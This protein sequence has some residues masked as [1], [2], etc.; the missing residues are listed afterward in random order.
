MSMDPKT[1]NALVHDRESEL[2]DDRFL[3]RYDGSI[4]RQVRRDLKRLMGAV[5]EARRALD[6]ACGTGYLA[7]GIA[8]AGIA[9]EVHATDLSPKMLE[10]C[11]DNAAAVGATVQTALSDAERLPYADDSFDLVCARG[12]LHHVPSPLEALCEM[13]RVLAPGGTAIV[14]AEPTPSGE[15]QVGTVVGAAV[16]VLEGARSVLR[17][18]RDEEHHQWELASMAA[19]LHTFE[20]D[21]IETLAIKAGFEDITVSTAA[22]AWV[23]ALGINY[24]LAGELRPLAANPLARTAGRVWVEGA[25][26]FDRAIGD[27]IVPR[28]WRHTVQA[29]L[30]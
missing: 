4:G 23:L 13:R 19:N 6:V 5:P 29:V 24:Y 25:A 1:L 30:R 27:R 16:R 28:E 7:I 22:W 10:R 26:M 17:V 2:Y 8:Y 11:R 20:P 21:H 9:A 3:I 14:L 12:A 18:K 15:K